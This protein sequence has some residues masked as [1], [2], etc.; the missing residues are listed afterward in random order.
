MTELI[1]DIKLTAHV[2][3]NVIFLTPRRYLF[4]LLF[5]VIL[6]TLQWL[7]NIDQLIDIVF[8]DNPLSFAERLSFLYDGFINIFKFAD[9]YVPVSMI[10]IAFMQAATIV[11]V[12]SFKTNRKQT[13]K[14]SLSMGLSLLG[15]GCVACGGSI[16][17]P[18]LAVVAANV[19]IGLVESISILLLGV[20]MVFSFVALTKSATIAAKGTVK[21]HA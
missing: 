7:F 16:L 9:N 18:L 12:L 20:G 4:L 11:L 14:Q 2:V 13:N 17:T 5:A 10:L 3:W 6:F 19:S 15:V 21:K 8:G 1:V